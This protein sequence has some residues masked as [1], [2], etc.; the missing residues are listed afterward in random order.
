MSMLLST[1]YHVV[2]KGFRYGT[3]ILHVHL[4]TLICASC[5][6]LMYVN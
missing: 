3:D 4:L 5:V 1:S 2:F 6:N